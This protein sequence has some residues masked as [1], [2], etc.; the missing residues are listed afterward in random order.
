MM[1]IFLILI[2][3]SQT[4][5]AS[6]HCLGNCT[7]SPRPV[8]I[9]SGAALCG[10]HMYPG[11]TKPT[12]DN[13]YLWMMSR[14]NGGNVVILTA[15]AEDT[16]CD[17]YNEYIYSNLTYTTTIKRPRSVT[18]I[19]FASRNTSFLPETS[20]LLQNAAAVFITGG[21]QAKYYKYWQNSPVS[22]LMLNVPVI[23]GSS[24]GLAVQGQFVFDA[25]NGGVDSELALK[26]PMDS[27][28]TLTNNLFHTFRY[29]LHVLT[30]T[31]FYQRDRMGRMMTFLARATKNKWGDNK[32]N[33]TQDVPVGILGVAISEHSAVLLDGESGKS[34]IVGDGPVY[35]LQPTPLVQPEVCEEG[36]PL[37]FENVTVRKWADGGG[38]GGGGGSSSVES[39]DF[40][41]NGWISSENLFEY[42]LSALEGV[43]K[44]STGNIYGSE[45]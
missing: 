44:S 12:D 21:D 19:C 6:F 29:M 8:N 15:D 7:T 40:N 27:E 16:P 35:F 32:N 5:T 2:F 39:F 28:I 26:Y 11:V 3:Q 23:G 37:T 20:L 34:T 17:L 30:D 1:L 14:I 4:I 33:D 10:G 24:A 18:T 22:R 13:V 42:K 38:G 45:N 25:L 41:F 9:K 36:K 43:L 31:H